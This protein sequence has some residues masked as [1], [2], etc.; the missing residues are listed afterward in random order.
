MDIIIILILIACNA[1]LA[2]AEIA[3]ISSDIDDMRTLAKRG[4]KAAETVLSFKE[5]PQQFLSSVQVGISL[6]GI[7]AGAVGGI[8]LAHYISPIFEA[9]NVAP[10]MAYK[11]AVFTVLAIITYSNILLG[12][13]LPKSI[14]LHQPEKMAIKLS[15]FILWLSRVFYPIVWLLSKSTHLLSQILGIPASKDH[16][17]SEDKIRSL[18]KLANK[19]GVLE[20]QEAIMLQN[21]FRF[22]NRYAQQIMTPVEKVTWLDLEKE[23]EI[24]AVIDNCKH[25]K[26]IVSRQHINNVIGFLNVKDYLSNL[27]IVDED[28][29]SI[30]RKPVRIDSNQNALEILE[31]FSEA[32]TY[33][34]I[35]YAKN[36]N[37]NLKGIITLHDLIQGVFGILPTKD[38]VIEPP[39]VIREDG[40]LL[41]SGQVLWD[42]IEEKLGVSY[43]FKEADRFETI[44]LYLVNKNPGMIFRGGEVLN[45]GPWCIEVLDVDGYR[46][47]KLSVKYI[48]EERP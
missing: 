19:E 38:Q 36:D 5:D 37:N 39:M 1:V 27:D 13:L 10:S 6:V 18:I 11:F 29:E 30:L 21:I 25:T 16:S 45:Y 44:A 23:A 12:E 3:V 47:D 28:L 32:K 42:E 43:P 31:R 24:K 2:L 8:S 48:E 14:A 9:F 4:D 26:F 41:V 20:N 40:S 33:F 17:V 15:S 35:V 46:I 34:G 7:S 22:A